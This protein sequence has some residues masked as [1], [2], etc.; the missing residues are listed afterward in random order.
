MADG[1]GQV[2]YFS[3]HCLLVLGID[4]YGMWNANTNEEK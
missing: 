4:S 3:S 2:I 1:I